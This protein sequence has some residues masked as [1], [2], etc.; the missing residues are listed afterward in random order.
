[1]KKELYIPSDKIRVSNETALKLWN[2]IENYEMPFGPEYLRYKFGWSDQ[3]SSKALDAY[4]KFSFLAHISKEQVTPS[5]IVDEVWHLHILHTLA[6]RN[7]SAICENFLH[8]HPG[9]PNEQIKWNGQYLKTIYL[10]REV[11]RE[12]PASSAWPLN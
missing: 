3:F 11:F 8:H 6:Y 1:M 12:E 5:Q 9:M 7:F 10:Y 4:K 2:A